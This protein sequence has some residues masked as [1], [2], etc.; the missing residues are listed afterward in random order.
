[1]ETEKWP[2]NSIL[3]QRPGSPEQSW[4][5][6]VAAVEAAI[7]VNVQLP[8]WMTDRIL[9]TTPTRKDQ[10]DFSM[11]GDSRPDGE[12]FHQGSQMT[13]AEFVERKFVPEY[14]ALKRAAGRNHFQAILKYILPP[15]QV[16]RAFGAN[17]D[18]SR[19]RLRAI[20]DWPYMASLRLSDVSP[21]SIQKLISASLHRGYSI[22]T[23]THIR[24]VIRAIFSHA[25]RSEY[26][27]GT[28]P[29]T[30]V[31]LPAMARKEAHA[32]TLTQLKQVMGRMRHPEKDIALFVIFTDMN[33]AEIC[34]L[35]WKFVNL[36]NDSHLVGK[37]LV[38][39]RTI[40]VR[41]QSYRGEFSP[42]IGRRIRI[43]AIP[44][45]LSSIL[46]ELRDRKKFATAEAF[47]L[48][49]RTGTS[50]YPDNIVA[51]RL[52]WIGKTLEMPWLSWN[53]FA[54]TRL[55]LTDEFGRHLHKE[56]EKVLPLRRSINRGS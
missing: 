44:D 49:S 31:L 33:V 20:P 41:N 39:P 32:L 24:N 13:L 23:V 5:G 46:R 8:I 40:A 29:A 53:V 48:T 18:K 47:V 36:S 50:I 12:T 56:F 30:L 35:Q 51:R 54:R 27:A 52:K 34:G 28:N 14:I 45:L 2:E 1:M 3:L 6:T 16:V 25:I 37:D 21:E 42:V 22:Q 11:S 38:P 19:V 17:P 7:D 10:I 15:E 4:S 55:K 9:A 26:F 43:I